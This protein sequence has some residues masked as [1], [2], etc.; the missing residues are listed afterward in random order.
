MNK[1][2]REITAAV[3]GATDEAILRRLAVECGVELAYVHGGRGK[4]YLDEKLLGF[5]SAARFAPW[6]VLRDLDR[7]ADCAPALVSRLL[8]APSEHMRF[9]IAEHASEAW[10]LAD[11]ERAARFLQV[12]MSVL[13][14]DVNTLLNPKGTLVSLAA[15]SRS[16]RIREDMA[17]ASRTTS[18]VGPAYLAR[19]AE[20]AS[21]SWRPS[22]A[23]EFSRSL[24]GCMR[25][26]ES[27]GST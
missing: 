21:E 27:W 19:I 10:L 8:P 15:R 2:R 11:R 4:A 5:N 22:V 17:P 7:D 12:P 13:P 25:V 24:A 16:V 1:A 20:F 3:E 9:R 18:R 6:L 14:A 23:R 26:L